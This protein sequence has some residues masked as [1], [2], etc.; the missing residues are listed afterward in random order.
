MIGGAENVA[1]HVRLLGDRVGI[2]ISIFS[3][4]TIAP[5]V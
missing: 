4:I 1:D 2:Q 5:A 3:A